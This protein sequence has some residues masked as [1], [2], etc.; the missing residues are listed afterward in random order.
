MTDSEPVNA[1]VAALQGLQTPLHVELESPV[2]LLHKE[3]VKSSPK[4]QSEIN[5]DLRRESCVTYLDKLLFCLPADRCFD[6]EHP[7]KQTSCT[8]LGGIKNELD[9]T[10]KAQVARYMVWFSHLDWHNQRKLV[11]EWMKY[12]IVM[13]QQV[14]GKRLFLLPGSSK[15]L[16]CKSAVARIIGFKRNAWGSLWRR[17]K[18]GKPAP[19]HG[20][21]LNSEDDETGNRSNPRQH[22]LMHQFFTQKS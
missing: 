3:W 13:Q 14:K 6:L 9:I 18:E 10:E 21:I 4:Q 20:L 11:M 15:H 17:V 16:V 5:I 19:I 8:C 7:L 22:E 1:A 2:K 12:S